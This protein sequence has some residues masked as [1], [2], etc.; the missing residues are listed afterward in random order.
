[1]KVCVALKR[2]PSNK[3]FAEYYQE[4]NYL[5]GD[6]AFLIPNNS[7]NVGLM[8][9]SEVVIGIIST[10]LRDVFSLGKKIYP[11]NFGPLELNSYMNFLNI[12]LKP[13]Q[14]EF[15]NQLE[16]LLKMSNKS[17]FSKYE[18]IFK[19]LGSFPQDVRPTERLSTLI[20]R[21]K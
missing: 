5:F 6:F 16:E 17:Y 15:N 18:H 2:S 7:S 11:I 13:S 3:D 14:E 10:S 19:Y 12:N 1:M 9:S 20:E 8:F 4:L 21:K